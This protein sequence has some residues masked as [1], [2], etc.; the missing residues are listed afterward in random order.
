[1]TQGADW[2][3]SLKRLR[4][5]LAPRPTNISTNS[6]ALI[7]K[8][9]TPASPATAFARRVFPVPGGPTSKAPRGIRAPKRLKRSGLRKNCTISSSSARTSSMPATS[10]KV[11]ASSSAFLAS[12]RAFLGAIGV[13]ADFLVAGRESM[14]SFARSK[15]R[16][17]FFP[18]RATRSS[19][20]E[21]ERRAP[22]GDAIR[23]NTRTKNRV[24][25]H[26]QSCTNQAGVVCATGRVF[27]T[28]WLLCSSGSRFASPLPGSRV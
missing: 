10:A 17:G 14:A 26:F 20:E 22:W 27:T 19:M 11:T 16:A 1:M 28:T 24:G 2:R 4:T 3:A 8:N 21:D 15:W 12:T 6:E 9:E 23:N 13:I 7:L 18:I 25:I 5:R